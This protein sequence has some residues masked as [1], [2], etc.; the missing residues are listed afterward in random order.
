MFRSHHGARRGI[1]AVGR[2]ATFSVATRAMRLLGLPFPYPERTLCRT[3]RSRTS[4]FACSSA[5]F[6]SLWPAMTWET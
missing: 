6:G 2:T 1:T 3:S 4:R 5:D